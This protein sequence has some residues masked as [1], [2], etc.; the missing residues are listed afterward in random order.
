[1]ATL[2][3]KV[4]GFISEY[5]PDLDY[6]ILLGN[7]VDNESAVNG[8]NYEFFVNSLEYYHHQR[9]I[10]TEEIKH[11]STGKLIGI[12]GSAR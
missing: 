1:M 4:K 3:Q 8:I 7:N 6:S 12:D 9:T 5:F 11:I 10:N 2:D